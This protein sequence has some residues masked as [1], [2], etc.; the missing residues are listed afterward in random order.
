M[1]V[2]AEILKN[3]LEQ[4]LIKMEKNNGIE[5]SDNWH[6]IYEVL[7]RLDLKE[8]KID[9]LDRPSA[10]TEIE[11]LFLKL[12]PIHDV[13]V[14]LPLDK[15]YHW[16]KEEGFKVSAEITVRADNIRPIIVECDSISSVEEFAEHIG[17]ER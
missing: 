6:N 10:A 1:C 12:L 5:R 4:K 7:A 16:C 11:Q 3:E 2:W 13:S 14:S 8:S 9:C 17:N 15:L